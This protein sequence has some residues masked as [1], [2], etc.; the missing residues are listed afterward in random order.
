LIG[1]KDFLPNI[2]G[3]FYL[4]HKKLVRF[5]Y[6]VEIEEINGTVEKI[7]LIETIIKTEK[8]DLLHIPNS[9]FYR[10]KVVVKN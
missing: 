3:W 5:N 4:K 9:L 1:I 7:G 2:F 10:K 8:G 6:L